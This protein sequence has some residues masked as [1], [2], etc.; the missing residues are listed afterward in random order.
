MFKKA[1]DRNYNYNLYCL[2]KVTEQEKRIPLLVDLV[3]AIILHQFVFLLFQL[4][5]A[6]LLGCFD[7]DSSSDLAEVTGILIMKDC[8]LHPCK[9]LTWL[10]VRV[11]ESFHFDC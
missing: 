3:S 5:M 9:L 6:P 10:H 7:V 2:L 11:S 8:F 4:K 1:K